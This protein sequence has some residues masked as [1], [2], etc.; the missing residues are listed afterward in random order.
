[1]ER[2]NN[3]YGVDHDIEYYDND[4]TQFTITLTKDGSPVN[5]TGKSVVMQVKKKKTDSSYEF[6]LT[7]SSGIEITGDDS[8]VITVT[9]TQNLEHRSY[10]YDLENTTDKKTIIYGLFKVIGEVTV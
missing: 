9:I 1:M 4:T 2:L 8:N 6:Q 7:E 3:I 5:L 10:Y